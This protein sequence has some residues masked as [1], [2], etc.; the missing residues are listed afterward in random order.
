MTIAEK[1]GELRDTIKEVRRQLHMI[2]PHSDQQLRDVRIQLTD[3]ER[4]LEQRMFD[5]YVSGE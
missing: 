5:Y 2:H 1:L 3:I 4:V